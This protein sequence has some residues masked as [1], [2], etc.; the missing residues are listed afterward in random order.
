MSHFLNDARWDV[1]HPS[2]LLSAVGLLVLFQEAEFEREEFGVIS[3]EPEHDR[4]AQVGVG[5]LCAI[6][7]DSTRYGQHTAR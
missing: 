4:V 6:A 5:K 3:W 7:G 2:K 1:D